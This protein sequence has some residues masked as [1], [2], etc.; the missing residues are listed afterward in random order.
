MKIFRRK[1]KKKIRKSISWENKGI[2]SFAG[3]VERPDILLTEKK[4]KGSEC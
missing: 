1:K 3:T 4:K 2:V